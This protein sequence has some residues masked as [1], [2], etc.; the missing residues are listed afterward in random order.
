MRYCL[1]N[2]LKLKIKIK[3]KDLCYDDTTNVVQGSD[4]T[5]T[6]N[7]TLGGLR[8]ENLRKKYGKGRFGQ[9]PQKWSPIWFKKKIKQ[10]KICV[11]ILKEIPGLTIGETTITESNYLAKNFKKEARTKET[12]KL[13][14]KTKIC[15]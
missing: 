3:I 10:S 9:E 1:L 5:Q 13:K 7:K 8:K 15:F 4:K 6:R 14:A 11:I 2:H 12:N